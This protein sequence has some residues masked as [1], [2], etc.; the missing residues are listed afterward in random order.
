M[1]VWEACTCPCRRACLAR[2]AA[3]V[4]PAPRSA[5]RTAPLC[6]SFVCLDLA[7]DSLAAPDTPIST[8]QLWHPGGHC[9]LPAGLVQRG[10]QLCSVACRKSHC[11]AAFR[12]CCAGVSG[13]CWK[14]ETQSLNPTFGGCAHSARPLPRPASPV[15]NLRCSQVLAG[16]GASPRGEPAS[17]SWHL[18]EPHC[19]L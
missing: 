4:G 13:I 3:S 5:A 6:Q 17:S 12:H 15:A 16:L 9:G 7:P 8:G 10:G 18:H 19:C 1:S 11:S 2:L 14:Q